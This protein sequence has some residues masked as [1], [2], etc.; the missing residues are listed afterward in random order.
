MSCS[1]RTTNC[2][3]NGGVSGDASGMWHGVLTF[4]H[5]RFENNQHV[6]VLTLD[7]S[8]NNQESISCLFFVSNHC[9][10]SG[11]F[12]GLFM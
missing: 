6:N 4:Q 10:D 1:F 8:S 3:S 5:C 11:D 7:F 9:I 12:R 2:P